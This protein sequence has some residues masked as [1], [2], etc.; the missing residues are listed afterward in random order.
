MAILAGLDVHRA[1]I[2]FDALN[3]ETGELLRARMRG[4]REA[5]G[6]WVRQFAGAHVKVALEAC[7]G[8]LFLSEVLAAAGAVADL[9]EPADDELVARQHAPCQERSRARALAA[10]AARRAAVGGRRGSRRRTCVSGRPRPRLGKTLIDDRTSWRQRIRGDGVSLAHRA[11]APEQLL[12]AEG[13]AFLRALTM[14]PAAAQRIDVAPAII[15][16]IDRHLVA[17][18]RERAALA[19]RQAGGQA[20]MHQ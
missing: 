3:T 7:T 17:L 18:E 11:P 6:E 12:R 14:P 1:Q 13:R 16:E 15:D 2:T 20:L 4:D 5:V 19:R 9:A 10:D 8:W